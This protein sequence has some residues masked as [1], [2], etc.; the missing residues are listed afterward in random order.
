MLIL[1]KLVYS[2]DHIYDDTN[3]VLTN[4]NAIT[5]SN[6]GETDLDVFF[7]DMA[8]QHL[9][10]NCMRVPAGESITLGGSQDAIIQDVLDLVFT[11]NDLYRGVNIIRETY[12]IL[13]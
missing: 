12:A 1:H 13:T 5:F 3:D 2:P 9:D 4:C 6:Y 10:G 8:H 11:R 7:N